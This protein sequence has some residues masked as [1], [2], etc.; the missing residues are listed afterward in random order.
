MLGAFGKAEENNFMSASA[1][2]NEAEY[3]AEEADTDARIGQTLGNYKIVEK[4]GAGGMGAIYLAE[5]NDAEIEKRVAVKIIKRGMDTDA[6][7]KR[8]RNE[9]QILA[10]LEHPNIARLLDA[11]TTG[12]GLPFF[13]MEYI[14]GVPV[15]EYCQT[16]NLSEAERLK[17]FRKICAAVSFAHQKLVVHR[18]LKPSNI[19][20]T[21]SGEPKLLD[22]G[23]AKLL[24]STEMETQARQQIL[25]PAYASPEQLRGELVSTASD[26][27]SLGLILREILGMQTEQRARILD[28]ET[29]SGESKLLLGRNSTLEN[30]KG[31]STG[32]QKTKTEN[33]RNL[34]GDLLAI[35][36]TALREDATR[37]YAS[38][39]SFSEDIRRYL[40]GLPVSARK[41]SL[42]YRTRKFVKRNKVSVSAAL[43]V[44]IILVGGVLGVWRQAKIAE[45]ERARAERQFENLRK[46][47]NSFVFEIH[48]AIEHLPGSLPARQLLVK[49]AVEQLDALVS[50]ASNNP[51]LSDELGQAYYTLG[52]MPGASLSE[53]N[54]TFQKGINIYQHLLTAEPNNTRY[55]KQLAEGF[56]G[57]GDVKKNSG[58]LAAALEDHRK[59]VE[60]FETVAREEPSVP[61][62]RGDLLKAYYNASTMLYQMGFARD[63]LE[64]MRPTL[65]IAE[66]M[67]RLHPDDIGY[68]RG[69]FLPRI[70]IAQSLMYLGDYKAAAEEFRICVAGAEMGLAK[71]PNDTRFPHDLWADN[72]HLARTL[73]LD[74][75]TNEAFR[76]ARISL[77]FIEDL[78]SKSPNDSGHRRNT[79]ITHLLLGQMLVRKGQPEKSLPHF[80]KAIAL[81]EKNLAFDTGLIESK[82]DLGRTRGSL[83]NALVLLGRKEDGLIYLREAIKIFEEVKAKDSQNAHL[84]RDYAENLLHLGEAFEKSANAENRIEA[85][86]LYTDSLEIWQEL[87]GKKI[88]S[89]ADS[90]QIALV[91]QKLKAVSPLHS[92][93]Q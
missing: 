59:A 24:N 62:H 32:K 76:R 19:L 53:K 54:L 50:E 74:G 75:E 88:L 80:E 22:F 43:L 49:R 39:D 5:R 29:K 40:E 57:R 65:S 13:V 77:S 69:L 6:I 27:Y 89:S 28:S 31:R 55:R 82:I 4:I 91:A 33:R 26:V 14:D 8:F 83:G 85:H 92:S 51:A 81:L 86:E 90:L 87:E 11:G 41:D 25:T 15:D 52:W 63:S 64:M 42:S 23:I 21:K 38:T 78:L 17:L 58:D 10:N 70:R 7:F 66:E 93:G 48:N 72:R 46:L 36:Q 79:A 34:S 37:R 12:D 67:H 16:K 45:A 44:F 47:S 9:R 18:D 71:Y 84:K 30:D 61:E 35:L 56:M 1:L 73:E 20:V 3:L 60:I 68:Y 2:E